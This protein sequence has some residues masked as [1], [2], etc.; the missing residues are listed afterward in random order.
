MKQQHDTEVEFSCFQPPPSCAHTTRTQ[1]DEN[2]QQQGREGL[3]V[4][5]P[6]NF[7]PLV[8]KYRYCM[9]IKKLSLGLHGPECHTDK[10]GI[11]GSRT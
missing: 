9:L 1:T 7:V 10:K 11:N 3:L 5:D 6:R 8:G 4:H 2:T